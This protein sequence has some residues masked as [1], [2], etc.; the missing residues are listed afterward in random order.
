M[1]GLG[2][3]VE[4]R[5]WLRALDA[6]GARLPTPMELAQAAEVEAA[7]RETADAEVARLREEL[8]CLRGDDI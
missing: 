4:D 5:L 7:R 8:R 1:G 2:L 3:Y 6:N